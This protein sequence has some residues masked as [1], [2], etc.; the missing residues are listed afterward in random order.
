MPSIRRI[1]VAVRDPRARTSPA[2]VKAAQLA[3]ALGARLELF[4]ALTFPI[5]ASSEPDFRAL[6]A[7]QR[8]QALQRL[9]RL[10]ERL[11]RGM[12]RAP[13][14]IQVCASW[15]APA[16]EA[17]IR[18][19]TQTG[20]DLIVAE[21]HQAGHLGGALLR[22]GDWELLRR[23]PIPVL[24]V[25]RGGRYRRPAAVL[26]AVDPSHA[27][28]KPA[29]LDDA[30]LAVA[31]EV[32]HALGARLHSVHANGA[33]DI[34]P[35]PARA[36][37]AEA[38]ARRY[39]KL[40]SEAS[41]RYE[42]LL[43]RHHVPRARRHLLNIPPAEAIEEVAGRLHADIVVAGAVSRTGWQRLLIGNTAEALL[44]PLGC[45]LL[46][47]KPP[48]FRLSIPRLPLGPRY[49]LAVPFTP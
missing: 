26:A 35:R 1:L 21:R 11:R 44:G 9:Q 10:A 31:T 45:D 18:R 32:S 29:R 27:M 14:D 12:H 13:A 25:K 34:L 39:R 36:L 7:E 37:D 4:H 47:V 49:Q 15:D 22:F 48:R 8:E 3:H 2:I 17:I 42:H 33:L 40:L 46:V 41:A 38:A 23:S 43:D 19:A 6:E 28:D 16:Y 20:A 5:Y 24:I 30:I